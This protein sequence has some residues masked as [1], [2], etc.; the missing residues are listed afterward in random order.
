MVLESRIL[1]VEMDGSLVNVNMPRKWVVDGETLTAQE[2]FDGETF[3][4]GDTVTI[5]AMKLEKTTEIHT[6][7][8][9]SAYAIETDGATAHA[10]LPFNI[11]T[12]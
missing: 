5:S 12:P 9:F 8:S 2:L 3:I 10:L 4:F 1:V 6:V 7:S 11:E